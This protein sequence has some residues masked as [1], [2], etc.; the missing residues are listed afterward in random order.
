MWGPEGPVQS[1]PDGLGNSS[2]GLHP[3]GVLLK[4]SMSKDKLVEEIKISHKM[5]GLVLLQCDHAAHVI[6]AGHT[7]TKLNMRHC[8]RSVHDPKFCS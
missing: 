4:D 2:Y 7:E 6:R 3:S 8:L 5:L 1:A